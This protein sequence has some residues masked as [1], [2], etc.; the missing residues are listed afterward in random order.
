[1]SK[2][3]TLTAYTNGCH[4]EDCRAAM[5]L[6]QKERRKKKYSRKLPEPWAKHGSSRL[7]QLGCRCDECKNWQHS[8]SLGK[9]GISREEFLTKLAAQR[10]S[11]AICNVEISQENA[12]VDHNH[13]N[14]E[15]RAL[16]CRNCNVGLGMFRDSIQNLK[17]A[18]SYLKTYSGS[19]SPS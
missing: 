17:H 3:G 12:H 19:N 11:C 14:G 9:Y 16:L 4:C 6:Y 8:R 10:N 5:A 15:V 7:Y 18:V 13:L 2:C 1:M